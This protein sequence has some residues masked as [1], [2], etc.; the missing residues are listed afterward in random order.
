MTRLRLCPTRDA[1][2]RDFRC[3]SRLAEFRR[4]APVNASSESVDQPDVV[5]R[6]AFQADKSCADR[7]DQR[8]QQDCSSDNSRAD[9]HGCGGSDV[10]RRGRTMSL[11][12]AMSSRCLKQGQCCAGIVNYEAMILATHLAKFLSATPARSIDF[13]ALSPVQRRPFEPPSSISLRF[14]ADCRLPAPE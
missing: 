9:Q 7:R 10:L 5:I 14:L 12:L 1:S 8:G 6:R 13:A 2:R 11:I 4:L 3:A